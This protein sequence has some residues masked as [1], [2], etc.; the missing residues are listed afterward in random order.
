VE[1]KMGLFKEFI[2]AIRSKGV[3]IDVEGEGI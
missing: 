2:E 3:T 1:G